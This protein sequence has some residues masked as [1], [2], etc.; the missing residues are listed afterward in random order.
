MGNALDILK[1]ELT[2]SSHV[3]EGKP[4]ETILDIKTYK[5][6]KGESIDAVAKHMQSNYNHVRLVDD[7]MTVHLKG[8]AVHS[9]GISVEQDLCKLLSKFSYAHIIIRDQYIEVIFEMK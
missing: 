6:P 3:V 2:E 5:T 9:D 4:K 8:K 7:G 1:Q